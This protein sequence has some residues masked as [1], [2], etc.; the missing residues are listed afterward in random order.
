MQHV[1]RVMGPQAASR[2]R[3]LAPPSRACRGGQSFQTTMLSWNARQRTPFLTTLSCEELPNGCRAAADAV[4]MEAMGR[5]L[6]RL[7]VH[8]Q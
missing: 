5:R 8:V 6:L 7:C 4:Q 2:R 3:W 1:G